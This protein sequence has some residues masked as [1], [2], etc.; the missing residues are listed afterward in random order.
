MTQELADSELLERWSRGDRRA[1]AQLLERHSQALY[2]FLRW[3]VPRDVEDVAQQTLLA[4]IERRQVWRGESSFRTYML[5]IARYQA[6]AQYRARQKAL[7]VTDAELH[8]LAPCPSQ[9]LMRL[10][11]ERSLSIALTRLPLMFS[12]VL[13]LAFYEELDSLQIA[14]RLGV[15]A[16]TVRSRQRRALVHLRRAIAELDQ[17][18]SGAGR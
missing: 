8:S 17:C 9:Q 15:P 5:S 18:S 2:N 13:R 16:P 3:R 1:G 10:Q 12:E 6:Y 4:C 7:R 11:D 14:A